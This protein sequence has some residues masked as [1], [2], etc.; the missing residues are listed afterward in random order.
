MPTGT[1]KKSEAS[2][3]LSPSSSAVLTPSPLPASSLESELA[4]GLK[5]TEELTSS[6]STSTTE[7]ACKTSN[8]SNIQ[9][10]KQGITV[11]FEV[12]LQYAP[13]AEDADASATKRKC[14]LPSC[15]V[16]DGS[17]STPL[18]SCAQCKT[19]RYCGR[20]HQTQDWKLGHKHEC[21]QWKTL[22]A[23]AVAA[24][25]LASAELKGGADEE[26]AGLNESKSNNT[27]TPSTSTA[28]VESKAI[29]DEDIASPPS[30]DTSSFP[31]ATRATASTFPLPLNFDRQDIACKLLCKIRLHLG[32]YTIAHYDKQGRGFAFVQS[33][34]TAHDLF[35][36]RPITSKGRPLERSVLIHFLTWGEFISVVLEDDFEYTVAREPLQ[37]ALA[38]YDPEDEYVV[39]LK[40]RCGFL[41]VMRVP[42]VPD[43][44]ACR[45]LAEDYQWADRTSVKLELD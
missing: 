17:S 29:Y 7:S 18:A 8:R 34:A 33:T 24:E 1:K 27:S 32:P 28:S 15:P 42:L 23:M 37:E 9:P 35:I 30:T 5:L 36:A 21:A 31:A 38:V 11:L 3:S 40:L 44:R 39:L 10:N 41:A 14:H 22:R 16:T 26:E 19:V 12:D 25:V 43:A 45:K 6:T 13:L 2:N 4:R 20:V